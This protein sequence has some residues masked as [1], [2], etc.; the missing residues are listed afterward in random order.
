MTHLRLLALS[1]CLGAAPAACKESAAQPP[2][3]AGASEQPA[4]PSASASSSP[5]A[6]R[7]IEPAVA[8]QWTL[9]AGDN[10]NTRYSSLDQINT[11]NVK[12]LKV[13]AMVSTGIA[14]GHE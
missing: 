4:A 10:A 6:I 13:A 7:L 1:C 3:P 11:Q 2:T 14:R 9:P 8:G 5:G 12:D